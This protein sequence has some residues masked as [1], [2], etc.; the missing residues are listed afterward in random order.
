MY[1]SQPRKIVLTILVAALTSLLS[2]PAMAHHGWGFYQEKFDVEMT[3]ERVAFG[4]PHDR[5]E[6][7]DS[8]GQRWNLLLAPPDRNEDFGYAASNFKVGEK[9]Q[10]IGQRNPRRNEGKVHFVNDLEGNNIYTYY[11][12]R[13]NTSWERENR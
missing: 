13:G 10:I 5:L 9:V 6:A 11:Y 12:S 7:V 4:F 8:E 1:N 2:L 3:I